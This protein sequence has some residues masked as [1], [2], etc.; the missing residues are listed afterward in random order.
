VHVLLALVDD[1]RVRAILHDLGLDDLQRP[2]DEHH[3][4]RGAALSDV[5][6]R[7]ELVRA[8]MA[9]E[10][11]PARPPVPAFERFTPDARQAIRGRSRDRSAARAPRSRPVSPTDRVCTGA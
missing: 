5:Q 10:P 4:P 3:P 8:A 1:G 9:E 2:V 11:Q 7:V 6:A